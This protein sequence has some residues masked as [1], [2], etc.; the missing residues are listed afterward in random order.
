[1]TEWSEKTVTLAGGLN[2]QLVCQGLSFGGPHRVELMGT[3][4]GPKGIPSRVADRHQVDVL[5]TEYL[6]VLYLKAV[7]EHDVRLG[8]V[9]VKDMQGG[10]DRLM[11]RPPVVGVKDFP[12]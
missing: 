12:T 10:V 5:E 11:G 6:L 3:I 2:D 4:T 8:L 7:R 1:M 9:E